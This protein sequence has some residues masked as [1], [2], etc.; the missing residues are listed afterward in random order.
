MKKNKLSIISEVGNW[1]G[2]NTDRY[3]D[4]TNNFMDYSQTVKLNNQFDKR[5]C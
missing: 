3:R 1:L 2:Q 4:L 5:L